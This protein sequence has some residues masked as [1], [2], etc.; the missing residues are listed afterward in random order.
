MGEPVGVTIGA[1]AGPSL[2]ASMRAASKR[3]AAPSRWRALSRC[4]STVS[5]RMPSSRA[6]CLDERCR[7]TSRRISRSRGVSRSTRSVGWVISDILIRS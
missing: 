6:I 1:L 2:W 7:S 3:V 5:L 4:S